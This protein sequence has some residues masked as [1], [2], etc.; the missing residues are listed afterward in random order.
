MNQWTICSMFVVIIIVVTVYIHKVKNLAMLEQRE[1]LLSALANHYASCKEPEGAAMF[2]M[3][4]IW[5]VVFKDDDVVVNT[6]MKH[7]DRSESAQL[8]KKVK[9]HESR[10]VAHGFV[11]DGP[12]TNTEHKSFSLAISR[13]DAYTVVALTPST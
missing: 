3:R 8:L 7:A 9:Q 13:N 2:N 12:N 6:F 4:D 5:F 11:W 1:M 10:H